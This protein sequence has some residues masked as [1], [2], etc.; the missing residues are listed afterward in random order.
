M[1]RPPDKSVEWKTIFLFVNQK[2][3]CGYSKEPSH[4]F[5]LMDKKIVTL[6]RC[7]FLL[8]W[9]YACMTYEDPYITATMIFT[10]LVT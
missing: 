3:C 1:Y 8:N 7:H 10:Q 2:I 4:I 9:P 5:K 6:L